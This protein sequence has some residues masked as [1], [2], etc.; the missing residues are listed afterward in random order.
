MAVYEA[1]IAVQVIRT[2]EVVLQVEADDVA[3]AGAK[4]EWKALG[5]KQVEL[6]RLA[7][8]KDDDTYYEGQETAVLD[9]GQVEEIPEEELRYHRHPGDGRW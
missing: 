5:M 7:D 8:D 4:L 6:D 1:R 3:E 9:V 2:Y